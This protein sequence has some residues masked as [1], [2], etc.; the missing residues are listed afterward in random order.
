MSSSRAASEAQP[1]LPSGQGASSK[2]TIESFKWLLFSSKINVFLVFVPLGLLAEW[3]HWGSLAVFTLNFLAIIPL[4][5][6]LGDATEQVS[7]RLG[8]TLGGLLNAT[9]GNAVELIVGVVALLQGQL[10]IVQMSLAGS[11]LSNLL[12]VLGFSFFAGGLF[13]PENSFAQTAAQASG[14]IMTLGCFTMVLPAAY[15]GALRGGGAKDMVLNAFKRP[16]DA[17]PDFDAMGGILFISRGTAV[18][19]LAIYIGYL[20]FQLRTH[21]FLYEAE[22]VEEEETEEMSPRSAIAALLLITLVTSFNADYLVSAIDDVANNYQISKVFIG[23]ILLPIVGN[24]AEHVTSVF[25]AAR[26][27]M[28]IALSVAIGSSVQICLGMVPVLV[29]VGWIVGQPLSLYFHDFETITLV[30][31][32]ILVNSLIQ[33]GKSNYLEGA[34][35]IA[36]Y[37]VIALSFWVQPL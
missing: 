32:V 25:M 9:F 6:L 14:S 22:E 37:S 27:K 20:V 28:E 29:I 10:R 19:L 5:K 35:L 21:S 17:E 2:T 18:I 13:Q 4:A 11:I 3:L 12:L 24:A 1:L 33:D 23:T 15:W 16:M 31:S 30:I 8:S 36:L 34:L 26:N 7:L